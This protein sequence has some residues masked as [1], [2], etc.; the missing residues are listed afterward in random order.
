MQAPPQD[1]TSSHEVG[2]LRSFADGKSQFIGS[3]S[4]V[5]FVNTVRQAF[6]A[7]DADVRPNSTSPQPS[8]EDCIIGDANDDDSIASRRT[9]R[10]VLNEV[11]EATVSYGPT[12]PKDLGNAPS[13][14]LARQLLVIYFR[15][16]HSLFP[17]LHG[18][19]LLDE[20]DQ[21]YSRNEISVDSRVPSSRRISRAIVFQCVFNLAS[22]DGPALPLESRLENLP[23]LIAHLATLAIR[24]DLESLQALLAAQ[25]LL[26][27]RM[28]LRESSALSGLLCRAIFQTGLHRCPVRYAEL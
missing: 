19:T 3:S 10:D 20:I 8:P 28:S 14:S 18:P 5:Y 23:S 13:Y 21:F 9:Q 15:T 7:A 24:S 22:L 16:W 25:L 26:V 2:I 17:F 27:A 11:E 4:G 12:I 6:S 1:L